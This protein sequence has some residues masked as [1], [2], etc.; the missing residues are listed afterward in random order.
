MKRCPWPTLKSKY[1]WRALIA[2]RTQVEDCKTRAPF[3]G[4]V[5][6]VHVQPGQNVALLSPLLEIVSDGP[7]HFAVEVPAVWLKHLHVGTEFTVYVE[8]V[9]KTYAARVL[10]IGNEVD[11]TTQ[12]I[13][14]IAQVMEK[15]MLIRSGM[16][17][18]AT[19]DLDDQ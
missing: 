3:A 18:A 5:H 17:G 12:T 11:V 7:W 9:D 14:V 19:F 4:R 15:D 2:C 13:M 10:R 6:K 1:R 8:A 16:R